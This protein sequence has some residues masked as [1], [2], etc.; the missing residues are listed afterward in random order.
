ME[1]RKEG[2]PAP[3]TMS[4][5]A[6]DKDS[7]LAEVRTQA[8]AD[9]RRD[10]PDVLVEPR[11]PAGFARIG[12]LCQERL[13]AA[14]VAA[15]EAVAADVEFAVT[16]AQALAAGL[17]ATTATSA[18]PEL[19]DSTQSRATAS[20]LALARDVLAAANRVLTGHAAHQAVLHDITAYH[21]GALADL[22]RL[23]RSEHRFGLHLAYQV[24]IT[25]DIP[26]ERHEIGLGRVRAA[27]DIPGAAEDTTTTDGVAA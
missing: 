20:R 27:I 7:A 1:T 13:A 11:L 6:V 24:P 3:P 18:I 9:A 23:I 5:W 26:A 10:L 25:I 12:T 19:A 14:Q 2:S 17:I 8:I 22:D 16:N 21:V 15:I 4:W